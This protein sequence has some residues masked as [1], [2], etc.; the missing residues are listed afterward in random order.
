M[1]LKFLLLVIISILVA[2]CGPQEVP[3]PQNPDEASQAIPTFDSTAD[4]GTSSENVVTEDAGGY[5]RA[6]YRAWEMQD[7][8][9]MYSL[10]A[11]QSQALVD[12]QSFVMRYEEAMKT[13]A[14]RNITARPVSLV[15]E[16]NEAQFGVQVTWE[17]AVFGPIVRDFTVPLVYDDGRWGIVWRE[18]LILPELE[19]GNRL[20]IEYKVPSRA[21]IYDINGYAL[22][23]QGKAISLG[24]VP[25]QIVD[26][27]GLLAVLSQVLGKTPDE[28]KEMYAQA[29]PDWYVPVGDIP[30]DIFQ[31]NVQTL[32]PYINAGL[33]PPEARNSRIYADSG[34]APHIVGYNGFIPA[35]EIESYLAQGYQ[36][37]EMV[38]RAGVEAWGED[39]L[40]GERGGTLSVVGSTGEFVTTMAEKDPLQS[41]SVYTTIDHTFQS[42]VERALAEAVETHPIGHAG[43]VVVLDVNNGNIKAMAS[44]PTY[45]PAIFD[46]LRPGS[47]VA[48]TNVLN[49]PGRPLIN[50]AAQGVYPAGSVFKIITLAAALNSGLYTPD[51]LYNSTGVWNRLGDEYAKTDWRSGGH[52]TVSLRQAL[53]VSCNT[54][55]YDVGYNLDGQDNTLLPRTAQQ[56]GLG[57]FTG[58]QGTAESPGLIPDPEWKMNN[59]GEGWAAGDAV[60]MAIG[61]GF[62]QVTPLQIA[63][64]LGAIA[65]GGTLY[66]PKLVDRIGAGGGAPE[67]PWPV[68]EKGKLPLSDDQLSVIRESLWNVANGPWG[69]AT[70][71][72]EGLPI[73][74]AGK[75]GTAEAPPYDSHAWFAGYAPAAPYTRADGTLIETPEIAIAVIIENAGEGSAVAAPV[76]RRIV[77]L[78]YG[79]EP[80]TPF[81][82]SS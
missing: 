79:I 77:E 80:L 13:A 33:A 73:Q 64:I 19:G 53:V 41:R 24:I 61:Q 20:T 8:L 82:W 6:F 59:R 62:V 32:Q 3:F 31:D 15:Q 7:Y 49:D 66:Q 43:A 10:L 27:S 52:G 51:T 76:F 26:E 17:T 60:N 40:N 58:L 21:G 2:A 63:T 65:N 45:D 18:G 69:T 68:S 71:R 28:I 48:L 36:G 37:D 55:F 72:F 44:Y 54:C 46:A 67:E 57:D 29:Q 1:K 16:G 9:G 34:V 23:F 4:I 14:V 42:A 75:T 25:G 50:R 12:S 78:Y 35:E 47:D 11:P 70:D 56:F 81:P 22:A 5:A 38:G 74:V 39:Y 30:E